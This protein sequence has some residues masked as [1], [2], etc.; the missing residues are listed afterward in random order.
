MWK[1][2]QRMPAFWQAGPKPNILWHGLL[3]ILAR[4]YYWVCMLRKACIRPK[5]AA[6]PVICVGNLTVGGAGKTPVAAAIAE[7]LHRRN[8]HAHICLRG[9]LGEMKG[10]LRVN[11]AIHNPEDIGDEALLLSR[12]APTWIGKNRLL[13]LR[14]AHLS[15]AEIAVLDDGLQ[16]YELRK[17]FSI[18]V[19]DG[20]FGFG[21]GHILPAGPLREPIS[22]LHKRIDAAIIVHDDLCGIRTHLPSNIPILQAKMHIMIP[23]ALHKQRVLAFCG[24]G[25]PQ[26]FFD[27]LQ[28]QDF[29][30][31]E[32]RAFS[33]HHRYSDLDM[34]TLILAAQAQGCHLLTTEKDF[35]RLS[36]T[37]R[38]QVSQVR[39]QLDFCESNWL[40]ILLTQNPKIL[41]KS[42]NLA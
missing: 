23:Q 25:R 29:D 22:A 4:L 42:A 8:W 20:G 11:P 38:N 3:R 7:E 10:P 9:Y 34:R 21:N 36:Q 26:K 31:I 33:D 30:L 5:S 1:N 35:V 24:I 2:W 12:I 27:S 32:T 14:E 39:L 17:D 16:H 15:G 18:L 19:I 40:D 37:Y 13:S 6:I 41:I 28:T